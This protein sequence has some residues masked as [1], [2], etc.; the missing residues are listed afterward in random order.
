MSDP[1]FSVQ[2][3]VCLVTGASSGIGR[4]FALT[5]AQR[6]AKVVIGARRVDKL[7]SLVEEAAR[8]QVH[9]LALDVTQSSSIA[10]FVK[11]A[12]DRFGRIDVLVNNA[13][14]AGPS[15]PSIEHT[16]RDW[17]AVM[18]VNLKGPWLLAQ[19]VGRVMGSQI[20]RGGSVINVGSILGIRVDQR[21][22]EYVAS[23]AAIHQ[24]TKALSLEW[25]REKIRVNAIAPG[26]F[27]TD[28][29]KTMF[30]DENPAGKKMLKRIPYRR[31]G[32]LHEL[33]G[34]LLLLCSDASSYM[35]GSV[36][37]VDGSHLNS[38]L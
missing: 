27:Y 14:S 24:L 22:V 16:E 25:A 9:A 23:K 33:D 20:P 6:G 10:S 3:K 5:L 38:A 19:A 30:D 13:G 12:V 18:D 21:Q 26:Y 1:L 32:E 17:D 4:S 2:D 35:S 34:A 15:S 11:G 7:N 36:V 28:I 29:N 37:V 8:F 31:L